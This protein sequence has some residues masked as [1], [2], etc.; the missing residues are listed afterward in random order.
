MASQEASAITR[1]AHKQTRLHT[2]TDE[3]FSQ[4][5]FGFVVCVI[6]AENIELKNADII[7]FECVAITNG[8]RVSMV[9]SDAF[10][11]DLQCLL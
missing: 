5:G 9:F 2:H 8:N 10:E 1:I 3:I 11:L 4:E 7:G 6:D